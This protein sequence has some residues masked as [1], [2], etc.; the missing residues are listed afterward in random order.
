[1]RARCRVEFIAAA[2]AVVMVAGPARADG[3]TELE[4]AYSAYVGHKYEDA[5]G[6]LRALLD[7]VTGT[8][9]DP[10]VVADAR[11]YLG[12]VLVAEGK[13]DEA[14]K[15]FEAL[16]IGKPDYEPDPLRVSTD[17]VDAYFDVRA[18]LRAH[19]ASAQ[20]EQA[21][22]EQEAR[23]RAEAERQRAAARTAL[24]ETLASEER[25]EHTNSRWIGLLP[26]GIGQFQNGDAVLGGLLMATESLLVVGSGIGAGL[27]LYDAGK[28]ND[29]NKRS[30]PTAQ[31]YETFAQQAS[32]TGNLL[33]AGF[34]LVAIA[35]VVQAQ[36]AFI[37][38]RVEVRKRTLPSL[39]LAPV[40]SLGGGG[41][42][43]VF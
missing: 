19:I 33:V 41:I 8:L 3:R 4:K 43:L 2:V 20:A 37:P 29:A 32:T 25:I 13:R 11:M 31:Q 12:A 5:E 30:D 27:A 26:L 23:A 16:L 1:M 38:E 10:D 36:I 40:P 17:A 9:R 35:G 18:R 28:A 42:G 34:A 14:G 21:R 6:R 39:S 7:P 15:V 24:L 22:L